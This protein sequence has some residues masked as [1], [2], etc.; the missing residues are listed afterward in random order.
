ME[1]K[2][3]QHFVENEDTFK[4]SNLEMTL[5]TTQSIKLYYDNVC[6]A[7]DKQPYSIFWKEAFDLI[8]KRYKKWQIKNISTAL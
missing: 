3:H 4:G 6:R 8:E 7:K 2:P 5:N 1:L